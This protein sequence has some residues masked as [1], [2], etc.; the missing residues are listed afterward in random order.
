MS[1][2]SI[3]A[4]RRGAIRL[5]VVYRLCR[6]EDLPALEWMGL[7]AAHR[8]II[9]TTFQDQTQGRAWMLLGIANDYPV[10]QAWIDP[11]LRGSVECPRL[12]AVRVFPAL[13]GSGIGTGLMRVA[14]DWI[15]RQG[16]NYAELGVEP[17]N[18]RARGFYERLG[19]K[20]ARHVEEHEESCGDW[21][22]RAITIRQ[23]IL[24]KPLSRGDDVLVD[25]QSRREHARATR[26]ALKGA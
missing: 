26:E 7:F 13:Q 17:E 18:A 23:A 20:F 16:A 5:T 12:W 6:E 14:E 11:Q 15:A 19:Y 8:D 10:A 24:R 22:R 21:C 2:Q 4:L 1:A 3:H 25:E 9:R